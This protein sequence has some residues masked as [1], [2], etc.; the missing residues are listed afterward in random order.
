MRWMIMPLRRYADFRGRSQPVEFW[1][2]M[3]FLL[4]ATPVLVALDVVLGL[5]GHNPFD[6][7]GS[8]TVLT[9]L[10]AILTSGG[11]LTWI[12]LLAALI[13]HYAV[14]VRRLHDT[15]RSGWW[16]LIPYAPYIFT[17]LVIIIGGAAQ[18]ITMIL[19]GALFSIVGLGGVI[20]LIIF[21]CLEGT[22]GE[23]DFG[24]DPRQPDDVQL[25]EMFA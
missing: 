12:F 19:L 18:S 9:M 14:Q 4:V 7:M 8:Y 20:T 11:L 3:L 21:L 1:M 25:G 10:V 23:N 2:W 6:R 15:N 13:P 22:R 5:G 17:L 16:V 24:R